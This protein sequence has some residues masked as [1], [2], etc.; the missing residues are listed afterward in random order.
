MALIVGILAVVVVGTMA[1]SE[2]AVAAFVNPIVGRLSDDAF[3]AARS[4]GARLLGRVMPF[5]YLASLALL[6]V[7]ALA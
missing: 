5:W 2:F 6:V 1:G 3:R 7:A 4:D